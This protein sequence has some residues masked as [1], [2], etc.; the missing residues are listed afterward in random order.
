[1]GGDNTYTTNYYYLLTLITDTA[2]DWLDV[3]Q[4][5]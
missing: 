4:W 1:M 3:N 2:T 5:N